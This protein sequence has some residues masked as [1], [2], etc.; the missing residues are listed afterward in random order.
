MKVFVTGGAGY[1]GSHT[2]V[3]LLQAGHDVIIADNLYNAKEDVIDKIERIT[4]R[5]P[6][7]YKVDV[8]D[9]SALRAIFSAHHPDAII[10]FA[11]YK[12]VGESC[13][14]P[15]AYYRNNLDS[16]LTLLE[17]MAEFGCTRFVFSSSATVYG[18]D[19]HAPY[20]ETMSA[21]VATNPYGWTKTMIE[22]ILRD[23]CAANPG[24]TAVL[25]RYFNPIGSHSS[26]LLGDDPNGIPNN[27][28][29]YIVR[30]ADGQLE[31]LTIFGNDYPTPDGTC[32]RDYLHVVDLA[33]G[34]L[35]ALEYAMEHTGA[36]PF[37]LGTGNGVSVK[38]LVDAFESATGV[39]VN[40]V[41]G[42]RRDGDLPA[43]WADATKARDVLGWTAEKTVE[44]MCR[45]SWNFIEQNKKA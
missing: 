36:E 37:N 8:A 6:A 38:E 35:K 32:Q 20:V 11:G 9:K 19:N 45:D 5:R 17:V 39:K 16:T 22:Q 41:Y 18:P 27:L 31:K 1:I 23:Y 43:F 7:F 4:G 25:L 30:V 3:E 33:R 42:P 10:H 24:F 28:M 40:H 2:C 15:L 44:D 21:H 26:G 12:A 34:H 29:P 14:I 13:R